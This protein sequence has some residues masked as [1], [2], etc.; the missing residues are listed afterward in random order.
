MAVEQRRSLRD[1]PA[2]S[3]ETKPAWRSSQRREDWHRTPRGNDPFSVMGRIADHMDRWFLSRPPGGEP[4]WVPELETF[5][6][7]DQFVV[8]VDLPGLKKE[9]VTVD[10][11]DEA[12]TI[13]GERRAEHEETRHGVF[14]SERSYGNFNRTVQL[15]E[16]ASAETAK[17]GFVNG[18]LEVTVDAPP[19]E[20]ARG[21]RLEISS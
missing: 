11:H 15:P 19:R 8:R 17:A 12:V 13:H 9:E 2:D 5:Q 4:A 1:R 10:V 14:T 16:G 3:P 18:V 21:R 20:T 7:G 6:R